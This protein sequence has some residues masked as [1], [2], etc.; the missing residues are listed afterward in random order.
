MMECNQPNIVI[1][2]KGI[3]ICK[4]SAVVGDRCTTKRKTKNVKVLLITYS[5]RWRDGVR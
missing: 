1:K 2:L 4:Q 5:K 3:E